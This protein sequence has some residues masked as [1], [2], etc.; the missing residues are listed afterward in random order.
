MEFTSTPDWTWIL[1]DGG[2]VPDQERADTL[3]LALSRYE[4]R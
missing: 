4:G 2:G 3:G 1:L